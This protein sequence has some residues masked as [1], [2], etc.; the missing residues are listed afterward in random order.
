[1]HTL[2]SMVGQFVVF[3][4]EWMAYAFDG[5][6]FVHASCVMK[7]R[8]LN[9][10]GIGTPFR[11]FYRPILDW[12][13]C[14]LPYYM[15]NIYNRSKEMI[16]HPSLFPCVWVSLCV[17]RCSWLANQL[18]Y[19][20]IKNLQCAH[21]KRLPHLLTYR[22]LTVSRCNSHTCPRLSLTRAVDVWWAKRKGKIKKQRKCECALRPTPLRDN[23]D[24]TNWT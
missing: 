24:R 7:E 3:N 14:A 4:F 15:L 17:S 21:S 9:Q 10:K 5:Y 8:Q 11:L 19:R 22:T 20:P 16:H 1:M 18:N 12:I 13:M 6:D 2:C 23:T